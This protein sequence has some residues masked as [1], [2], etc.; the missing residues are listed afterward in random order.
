VVG[1]CEKVVPRVVLKR[2]LQEGV[3]SMVCWGRVESGTEQVVCL[4]CFGVV[5]SVGWIRVRVRESFC[6]GAA[7][8]C[9]ACDV[10][11]WRERFAV[12]TL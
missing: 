5:L 6:V 1:G 3:L 2:C 8:A 7:L 4:L 9:S 10:L 12:L 11:V